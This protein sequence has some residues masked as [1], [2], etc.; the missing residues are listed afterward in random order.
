VIALS[1]RGLVAA[2]VWLLAG[3]NSDL[4]VAAVAHLAPAGAD[5]TV[6]RV[7]THPFLARFNLTLTVGSSGGCVATSDL[8]PDTGGVS[9]RNVYRGSADRLYIVGQFDVRRFDPRSCR[10]EL[11]EFGSLETGLLYLGT[12]DTDASGGWKFFSS[13]LRSERPFPPP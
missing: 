8:F 1:R 13:D 6:T 2:V 3:C 9:R 7:A 5:V 10:I 4:P 12:F 11:M